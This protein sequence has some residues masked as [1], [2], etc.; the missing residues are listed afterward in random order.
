MNPSSLLGLTLALFLT[1]TA[2]AD[3]YDEAVAA[4]ARPEND[5]RRDAL[6]EPAAVLRELAIGDERHVLDAGTGGGYYAELLARV[7]G[8]ESRVYAQNP[9]AIY[10]LFGD[11]GLRKRLADNRLPNVIRWDRE[12]T[13]L[14]LDDGSLDLVFFH[15]IYHDMYWIYPGRMAEVHAELMRVLRPGGRVVIIDHAA[16]IGSRDTHALKREGE[17]HRIDEDYVREVLEAAGFEFVSASDRLRNPEDDRTQAFFSADLRG[18]KT[19]RFMHVYRKP[20][21]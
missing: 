12:M 17:I 21:G 20:E 6:R 10:D 5:L 19:D 3:R 4:E 1:G 2:W 8:P 9:Q 13:A 14:D 15:L 11:E 16:P 7:T 18:K